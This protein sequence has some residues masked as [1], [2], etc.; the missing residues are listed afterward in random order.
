MDKIIYFR[1]LREHPRP[2]KNPCLGPFLRYKVCFLKFEHTQFDTS[3]SC[4]TSGVKPKLEECGPYVFRE[5][6]QK[7]DVTFNENDTISYRQVKISYIH[8]VR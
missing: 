1:D 4:F 2:F 6:R 7:V 3:I 5:E 8:G